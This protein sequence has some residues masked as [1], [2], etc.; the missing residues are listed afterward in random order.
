MRLL[1]RHNKSRE[2]VMVF[3]CKTL[4][5]CPQRVRSKAVERNVNWCLTIDF[6]GSDF[7]KQNGENF[8]NN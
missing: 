7:R 2:T 6:H 4:Y 3:P 1:V 5:T 8:T